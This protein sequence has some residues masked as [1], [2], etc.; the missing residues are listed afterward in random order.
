MAGILEGM[1]EGVFGFASGF[2]MVLAMSPSICPNPPNAWESPPPPPVN[3]LAVKAVVDAI[4]LGMLV[5]P[6]RD[7][8]FNSGPRL[9]SAP[10][11]MPACVR[12]AAAMGTAGGA[13]V[14]VMEAI[15]GVLTN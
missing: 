12:L 2:I 10:L 4:L 13:A 14:G 5:E 11:V 15:C 3:G 1:L 7:T 9:E 6:N 8:G